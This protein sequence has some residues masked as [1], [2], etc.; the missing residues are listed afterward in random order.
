[1]RIA[2][3][4]R[5]SFKDNTGAWVLFGLLIVSIYGNYQNGH[6]L[7]LICGDI[8]DMTREP[9]FPARDVMAAWQKNRDG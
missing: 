1:M 2:H 9:P 7:R 8:Q 6:R 3:R 4:V 5:E